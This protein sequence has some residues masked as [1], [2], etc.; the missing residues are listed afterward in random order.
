MSILFL[1]FLT[2]GVQRQS[3][4]SKTIIFGRAFGA[5]EL[6]ENAFEDDNE[7]RLKLRVRVCLSVRS[8]RLLG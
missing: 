2:S 1:S 6:L 4:R 5:I 7:I 8:M 3:S